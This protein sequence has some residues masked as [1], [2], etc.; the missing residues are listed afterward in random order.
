[1]AYDLNNLA[2]VAA[3]T[4]PPYSVLPYAVWPLTSGLVGVDGNSNEKGGGAVYDPI[5]KR[6]YFSATY[7]DGVLPLIQVW[8]VNTPGGGSSPPTSPNNLQVQ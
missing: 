1:M 3:G 4:K 5:L 8:Q 7:T 2:A 6:I